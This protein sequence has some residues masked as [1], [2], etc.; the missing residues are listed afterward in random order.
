M[1]KTI[2]LTITVNKGGSGKTTLS[3]NL[4]YVLA[5]KGYRVLGI[6]TDGQ[7]NFSRTFGMYDVNEKNFYE[8]FIKKEDIRNHILKT[9]YENI[10][11]VIGDVALS[12][13]EKNMYSMDFRELRMSEILEGVKKEGIYDFIIIDTSPSIGML[14]T[15]IL[16]ATD[17]V[18][19]P[20]EATAFGVDGLGIFMEHYKSVKTYNKNLN[21]LGIVL[22]KIDL[23][24]NLTEDVREIIEGV[25]DN[26]LLK[27]E[28]LVDANIKNSQ[29]ASSTVTSSFKNS[30]AAVCFESL[31]EEVIQIVKNR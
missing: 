5:Q 12:L 14:N 22:N 2:V 27:T 6:D 4:C 19:I 3:S 23:R 28:I 31:A 17:E 25:F 7:K 24:E 18:L 9:E 21:M 30:R 1:K 10:D 26:K 8:A 13:I 16:H 20:V 29:W 15:S 11:I